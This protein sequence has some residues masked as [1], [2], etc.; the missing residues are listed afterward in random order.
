MRRKRL[1]GLAALAACFA[2]G[3]ALLLNLS[4][5]E[6]RANIGLQL[7]AEGFNSPVH[8]VS[9]PDGSGAFSSSTESALFMSSRPRVSC[10][11]NRSWI[12]GTTWSSCGLPSMSGACSG[13]LSTR[14]TQ[15]T[16][17]F[18]YIT[19]PRGDP[20]HRPTG[21]TRR[22]S[23]EFMASTDNSNRADPNSERIILEVDQPQFNHNAG[24]LAFGPDG[25]LYIA[26]G[27]G[28]GAN[29]QGVGHSPMG[30]AQ[31]STSYWAKFCASTWTAGSRMQFP[32]T[33]RLWMETGGMK[34]SPGDSAIRFGWPLIG[35]AVMSCLS[36]T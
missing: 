5:T 20:R 33:T 25:Y 35:A 17:D 19:A 8:L 32:M 26:L 12:C 21:I 1:F 24:A 23:S 22:A 4:A 6:S 34:F 7:V 30:N 9:P 14:T 29:N 27:D 11:S 13:W 15:T 3:V 36:P 31:I 18:T 16:V 28:G 2:L 10:W